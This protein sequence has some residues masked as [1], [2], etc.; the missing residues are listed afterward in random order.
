MCKCSQ[1]QAYI[2][3]LELKFLEVHIQKRRRH[4]LLSYQLFGGDITDNFEFSVTAVLFRR[5][6]VTDLRSV[7][8]LEKISKLQKTNSKFKVY[9]SVSP[10]VYGSVFRPIL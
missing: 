2:F 8:V 4:L 6:T 1:N 5:V 7:Q 10:L 3:L 9:S